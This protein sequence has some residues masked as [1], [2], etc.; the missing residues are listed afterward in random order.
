LNPAATDL[1]FAIAHH[2]LVFSLA[3]LIAFEI[4]AI[5]VEVT[6]RDIARIARVDMW[7]GILAAAILIV[8][9]SRAVYAAKGW[10]YYSH[11]LL[12]WAKI[13]TFAVIGL[14]SIAPTVSILRWRR[15]SLSNAGFV[16]QLAEVQD[17]R[18]YLLAEAALFP[19]LLVF[20]AAMARGYGVIP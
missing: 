2:L 9:F 20:A 3:A 15:N 10:A 1:T 18:R 13:G 7:Y 14:L 6:G 17:V 4:A 12:F 5:R 19:L 16:V 11:N 8:G